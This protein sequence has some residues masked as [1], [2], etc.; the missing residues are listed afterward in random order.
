MALNHRPLYQGLVESPC[1]KICDFDAGIGLCRCCGRTLD[2]ISSW[3][4]LDADA[5][6]RIMAELPLRLA[7]I[8]PAST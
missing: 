1:V 6:N 3:A 8:N 5:R 4:V 7:A 2:E